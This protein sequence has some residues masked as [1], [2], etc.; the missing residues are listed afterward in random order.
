[1]VISITGGG[2]G[3]W[4]TDTNMTTA[5][6]FNYMVNSVTFALDG[7]GNSEM[8]FRLNND[9]AVTWGGG[10]YP[11]GTM[12]E[13]GGNVAVPV[14]TYSVTFNR[15][16]GVFAFDAPT[17]GI[18]TAVL[19]I[20]KAYPNPSNSAWT[21]AAGNAVISYIQIV[22]LSGKVIL[23]QNANGNQ[24]VVDASA[25]ASGVYFAKVTAG[26]AATTVKVV[27]N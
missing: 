7:D 16:T 24:A 5:D 12:Q 6:G 22:D 14:G 20:V 21:F 10:T 26:D 25:L 11:S 3:G 15:S 17:A 8:K 9:W 13:G 1:V 4:G 2:V 18:E 27:K 23:S 19:A